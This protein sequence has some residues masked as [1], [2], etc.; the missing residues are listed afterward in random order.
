[1]VDVYEKSG[2]SLG[3]PKQNCCGMP[4]LEAGD[5][6]LAREMAESNVASLLPYV[7]AKR[8][9]VAVNPTC[10]YMLRK[11]YASLVGT[12]AAKKVAANTM[13]VSEFLFERKREGFLNRNFKST[14]GTIPYH[15]PCHLKAQNL[16]FLSRDL[17]RAIPGAKVTMVQ[18]CSAHDGTWA[19]KKE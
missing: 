14:P 16:G 15:L 11:E 2:I 9:V 13:D 1:V 3:C 7:E 18:Q 12:P 4:A 10:S 17:M 19:M 6:R 8:K 5:V